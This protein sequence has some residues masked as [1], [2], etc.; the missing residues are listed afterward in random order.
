MRLRRHA[1][2]RNQCMPLLCQDVVTYTN[3]EIES[4][5]CV[6]GDVSCNDAPAV[7]SPDDDDIAGPQS[8][9]SQGGSSR[10][11]CVGLFKVSFDTR[12]KRAP[13]VQDW[14]C[15][16]DLQGLFRSGRVTK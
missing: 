14:V 4:Y 6:G 15:V 12:L 9:T 5:P 16:S 2:L 3:S 10:N 11:F 13:A 7:P 1:N 8:P